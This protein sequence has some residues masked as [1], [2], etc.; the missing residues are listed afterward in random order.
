MV[1]EVSESAVI[2]A[3]CGTDE[4]RRDLAIE[5][6]IY[7]R[8]GSHPYIAKVLYKHKGMIVLER[9][10][11]PLRKRLWDLRAAQQLPPTQDVLR[12]AS[13][14]AE[15]LQHVHSCGVFQVDIGPHN[16]LLDW[17]EDVKLSDFAGASVDGS[18]PY[19][20]P[21]PHSEHPKMR[22]T[23][24]SIQSEVFALGSALY[25]ME[26]TQQPYH[27][28]EDEEIEELFGAGEFPDTSALI[29][30]EVIQKCWR[31]EYRDAGEAAHD[32]KCIRKQFNDRRANTLE[33]KSGQPWWMDYIIVSTSIV[34]LV[35]LFTYRKHRH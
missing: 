29:L 17:A 30:G 7:E 5:C 14:I 33:E 21:S 25:E 31:M 13:Q 35:A 15:A 22:A 23:Q 12:W 6:T 24:P 3:P 9:L 2:K 16:M 34:F 10:Q 20:L 1:F 4:S 19:V 11:Y 27:D 32:V 8:L 28:K 18:A 26:T